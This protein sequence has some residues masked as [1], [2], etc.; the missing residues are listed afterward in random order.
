LR[1]S[2]DTAK[3]GRLIR[4]ITVAVIGVGGLL[5]GVLTA[6]G[7][8]AAPRAATVKADTVVPISAGLGAGRAHNVSQI[9]TG[10]VATRSGVVYVADAQGF[11]RALVPDTRREAFVAGTLTGST[12][13]GVSAAATTLN[14]ELEDPAL[15]GVTTDA[16]G[17]LVVADADLDVV[18]IL[19]ESSA[20]RYGVKMTKGDIYTVA[21][22]LGVS[23]GGTFSGEG[24]QATAAE[25]D[26]PDAVTTDSAGDLIIA[27]TGDNEVQVVAASTGRHFGQAMTAGDIYTVAGDGHSGITVSGTAALAGELD[28]PDG[29]VVTPLGVAIAEGGSAQVTV[30]ATATG[31]E[32]GVSMPAAADLYV[33]VGKAGT[34]GDS[35]NGGAATVAEINGPAGLAVDPAGDLFIADSDNHVVRVVAAASHAIFGTAAAIKGD[36]YAVAGT[37][38][39][40]G[41]GN[42]GLAT[43]ADLSFPFAVAIDASGNLLIGDPGT[44]NVD[45]VAVKTGKS[46]NQL[47]K[48]DHLYYIAGNDLYLSSGYDAPALEAENNLPIYDAVAPDGDIAY[49]DLGEFGRE[50][51][52]EQGAARTQAF[53]PDVF[54]RASAAGKHP[55]FSHPD[56]PGVTATRV[57]VVAAKGGVDFGMKMVAGDVYTIGGGP[58]YHGVPPAGQLGVHYGFG[59]AVGVAYDH[60]GN[61]IVS[62]DLASFVDVIAATTGTFY[63]Q[64]MTAG[65][66][67]H[68]GGTGEEVESPRKLGTP[69]VD[70]QIINPV[71][72]AV[73][74]A[75]NV[76][77][78]VLGESSDAD[79]VVLVIA[80]KAGTYYQQ[81]MTA[82][83]IYTIVGDGTDGDTGDG[84]AATAA[85][86]EPVYGLAVDSAGDVAIDSAIGTSDDFGPSTVRVVAETA[87]KHFGQAMTVGN[88]YTVAGTTAT[89]IKGYGNGGPASAATLAGPAGLAF[90][91]DGSLVVSDT[92][93]FEVRLIAASNSTRFGIPMTANDIYDV[94]GNGQ[95]GRTAYPVKGTATSVDFVYGVAVAPT[96]DLVFDEEFSGTIASV[97]A[98]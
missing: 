47:T 2:I 53:G 33:V 51:G 77:I 63:G 85:E 61:V 41:S 39:L 55:L 52:P 56:G 1:A 23:S 58:A 75:G 81:A 11:L 80:A 4:R 73:D 89:P 20:T 25:L 93:D 42:N 83:D 16:A 54:G 60:H 86:I 28:T 24:G 91:A 45:L 67:Y 5:G 40:G 68:L 48:A 84:G 96:G 49:A 30:L 66:V 35:G 95:V 21:G 65:H 43:S 18:R 46:Y 38:T 9:P 82:G 98:K 17:D 37:G 8:A 13:N 27:D 31:D 94:V 57:R 71:A 29:L 88:I 97:T 22:Q 76:L 50:E 19:A 59:G 7:A 6:G 87:G 90:T 64:K 14:P 10:L 26:G 34:A 92:G 70:A 15:L 72:V 74:A 12:A 62:D 79:A 32:Y 78:A 3:R 44:A 36:I 69:A